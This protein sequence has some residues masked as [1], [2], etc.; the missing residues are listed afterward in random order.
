LGVAGLCGK[1][2][3]KQRLKTIRGK[4]NSRHAKTQG[5]LRA[6]KAI[7]ALVQRQMHFVCATSVCRK[8]RMRIGTELV[9]IVMADFQQ[10]ASEHITHN[11]KSGDR[12]M[13]A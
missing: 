8:G 9:L 4:D 13:D 7:M 3:H 10:H 12:F 6:G 2:P 1:I 11:K 5:G